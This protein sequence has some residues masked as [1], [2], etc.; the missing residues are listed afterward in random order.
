MV[1]AALGHFAW[2]AIHPS[3]PKT[4]CVISQNVASVGLMGSLEVLSFIVEQHQ[5]GI[6]FLQ[7]CRIAAH[8]KCIASAQLRWLFPLYQFPQY[9]FFYS[10]WD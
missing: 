1:A 6:V 10:L 8:E 4:T 3:D 7:D 2:A 5:A 9:C